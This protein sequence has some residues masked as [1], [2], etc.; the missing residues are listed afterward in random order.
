MASAAAGLALAALGITLPAPRIPHGRAAAGGSTRAG[1]PPPHPR[2]LAAGAAV[3]AAAVAVAVPALTHPGSEGLS[4]EYGT[5]RRGDCRGREALVS[6]DNTSV[7]LVTGKTVR[8]GSVTGGTRFVADDRM[9][10]VSEG[11]VDSV[12]LDATA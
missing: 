2:W 1:A 12:R 9:I 7:D 3:L 6:P 11:R 4:G 10:V 8:L 5:G